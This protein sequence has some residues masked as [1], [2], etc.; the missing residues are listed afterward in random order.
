MTCDLEQKISSSDTRFLGRE[1]VESWILRL[2]RAFEFVQ[3]S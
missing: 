2:E 3:I 1:E